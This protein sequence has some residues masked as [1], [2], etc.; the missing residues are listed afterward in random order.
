M[1]IV[2]AVQKKLRTLLLLP[3][4]GLLLDRNSREYE[5]GSL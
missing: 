4:L 5:V 3:F 2:L 1:T